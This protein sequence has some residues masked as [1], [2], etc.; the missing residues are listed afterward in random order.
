MKPS[1]AASFTAAIILAASAAA[2]AAVTSAG[3]PVD[4][5][6]TAEA[7]CAASCCGAGSTP[8]EVISIG[9]VAETAPGADHG[10]PAA[11]E[12]MKQRLG[13][14]YAAGPDGEPTD[15]IMSEFRLTA[16]GSAI[17]E[18]LFPGKPHE[19]I[20]MY[21]VEDGRLH[22]V[23]YCVLKNRPH[24]IAHTGSSANE[25]VFQCVPND[26]AAKDGAAHMGRGVVRYIGTDR[27]SS[28]WNKIEA[29]AVAEAMHFEM[30][31]VPAGE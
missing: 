4:A 19:M 21:H 23:H 1:H 10:G 25:L 15:E 27:I 30:I 22:M 2:I 18:T 28:D 3:P 9:A 31:R 14:W 11:F 26:P 6:S 29:G 20:S 12:M 24:L 7:P 8:G 16:G 13:T 17:I 5:I